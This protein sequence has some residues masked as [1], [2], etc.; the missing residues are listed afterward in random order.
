ME[1]NF[2]GRFKDKP[3]DVW[4]REG[5]SEEDWI[6]R[7]NPNGRLRSATLNCIRKP[8]EGQSVGDW[9]KKVPTVTLPAKVQRTAQNH[10]RGD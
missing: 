1:A 8:K 5:E 10:Y 2:Y 3:E 9:K 7:I 6:H 4:Q